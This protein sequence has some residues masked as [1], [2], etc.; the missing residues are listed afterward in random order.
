VQV[1]GSAQGE[2]VLEVAY[3][4]GPLGGVLRGREPVNL[5]R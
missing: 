4:V 5:T 3:D 1:P 2:I